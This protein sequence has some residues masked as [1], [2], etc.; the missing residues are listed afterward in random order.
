MKLKIPLNELIFWE[1]VTL[2][3]SE[4]IGSINIIIFLLLFLALDRAFWVT[5]RELEGYI[6]I[7]LALSPY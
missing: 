6:F 3:C 2:V 1:E 7:F 4:V 5:N